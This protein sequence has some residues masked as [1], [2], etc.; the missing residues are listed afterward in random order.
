MVIATFRL[1]LASLILLPF[2]WR[3]VWP[4]IRKLSTAKLLLCLLAGVFLALHFG[5]WVSSLSYT[6]VVTSVVLVTADP[7]FVAIASFLL[8]HESVKRNTVLGTAICFIGVGLIAY[9]NLE[10]GGN[11]LLGAI[12]ALLAS[13]AVAGYLII[14]RKMRS[15]I[16]LLP[17]ITLVYSTA[18]VLTLVLT[19]SLGY[20]LTGYSGNTYLMM[21]LLAVVPQLI[22]HSSVNWVLRHVSATL[23]TI[24]FLGEPIAATLWALLIL[25]EAP[26]AMEIVGGSLVLAGIFLA[27][28]RRSRAIR[29]RSVNLAQKAE[30]T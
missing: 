6:S 25:R 3:R 7:I 20:G 29:E 11:S 30:Q 16:S 21:L 23:V 4:E 5:L 1:C 27:F 24:A 28:Y 22:G 8:L 14:G 13:M 9:S 2:V 18:A 10:V 12:L 19:M 26:S 17:Y 15:G